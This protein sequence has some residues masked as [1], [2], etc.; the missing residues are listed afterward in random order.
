MN[1]MIV[2]LKHGLGDIVYLKTDKEQLK[3][4]VVQISIR[5]DGCM[6]ELG[7]NGYS[8]FHYDFEFSADKD[9]LESVI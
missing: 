1:M 3:R 7:C 4:M 9:V 8:S 5:Q 6:Y 2:T